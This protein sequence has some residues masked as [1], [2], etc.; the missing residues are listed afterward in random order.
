MYDTFSE[1]QYVKQIYMT[2][3]NFIYMYNK[4]L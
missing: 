1:R 2:Q 4:M 3:N